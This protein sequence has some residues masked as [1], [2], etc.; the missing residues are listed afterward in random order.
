MMALKVMCIFFYANKREI[1]L[2]N[3]VLFF[4]RYSNRRWLF[5]LILSRLR[6]DEGHWI[7]LS[8]HSLRMSL[9]KA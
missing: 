1:S 6:G 7:K 2:E 5:A 4:Q 8:I 9:V 3:L